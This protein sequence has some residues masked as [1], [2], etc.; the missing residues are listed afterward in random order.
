MGTRLL[1]SIVV[2]ACAATAG[3]STPPVGSRVYAVTGG[4]EDASISRRNPS[5]LAQIG[6]TASLGE[7]AAW[8]TLS[9]DGSLLA[10]LALNRRPVSLR[11]LD[12]RRMR[13]R[14]PVELPQLG[15]AAIRWTDERTVLVLGERPDGLRAIAVDVGRNRIAR[16]IRVPGHLEAQY[17]EPTELGTALLLRPLAFRQQGPV[18]LGVVRASGAV[19]TVELS[20]I[21]LGSINRS[22]R[23]PTLIAD[24]DSGR[25]YVLGGL[26]EPVAEID[27]RDLH[28]S[29]HALRGLRPLPN[30][31]A[32][33]R[34]GAWIGGGRLALVGFDDSPASTARLGLSIVDTKTWRLK[35]I[36]PD[37][38]FMIKSGELLLALHLDQSLRIFNLDGKGVLTSREQIFQLGAVAA[39]GR[40]VYAYNL[41]PGSQASAL[42]V[43]ARTGAAVWRPQVSLLGPVLSPGLIVPRS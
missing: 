36:D 4:L 38:D 12:L 29:Y 35:R 15:F 16:R 28:V 27:L 18:I 41:P 39:N 3:A 9:P 34:R 37:A 25:A 20:R 17:A 1:T 42:V 10:A 43:D 26:D 24:A 40:Y 32:S 19:R 31:I 23:R 7:W 33:D 6:P 11:V 2:L 22:I 8:P 5:T 13:W 30:T 21:L 14:A